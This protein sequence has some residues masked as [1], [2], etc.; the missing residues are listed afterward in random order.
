M[1]ILL[2]APSQNRNIQVIPFVDCGDE[3]LSLFTILQV[4]PGRYSVAGSGVRL[5][6]IESLVLIDMYSFRYIPATKIDIIMKRLVIGIL[7][8]VDAGKLLYRKVCYI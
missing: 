6:S 8:H 3:I 2:G 5:V 4:L 7:A 1:I